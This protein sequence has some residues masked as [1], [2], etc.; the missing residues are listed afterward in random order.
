MR[1]SDALREMLAFARAILD[2]GEVSDGEAT[3]FFAWIQAN[4]DLRGLQGV[5]EMV[6]LMTNAFADGHLSEPERSSLL[7]ALERFGG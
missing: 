4:P 5:D 3:S 2:D 1:R 6:E 7:E